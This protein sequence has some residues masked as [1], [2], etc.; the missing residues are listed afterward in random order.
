MLGS[1]LGTNVKQ[2]ISI[3]ILISLFV[4]LLSGFSATVNAA[5]LELTPATLNYVKYADKNVSYDGTVGSNYYDAKTYELSGQKYLRVSVL[6][7]AINLKLEIDGVTPTVVS[8]VYNDDDVVTAKVFDYPIESFTAPL[9]GRITYSAGG[10]QGNHPTYIVI[11]QDATANTR[12]ALKAKLLE[13]NAITNKS[14]ALTQAIAVANSVDH[15]LSREAELQAQ[16]TAL[17]T[18]IAKESVELTAATLNYVKYSD[19]NVSYDGTVGS[20]YYDA[21]TYALDGQKYL[22]V[23]VLES[24]INLKL[25]ID[26]VT[27][28]VV[29]SVYND[30]NVV[31][32][33]VFDYP[34]ESFTTPLAGRITY[35][36]GGFQGNHPTYIIINQDA[37]ADTRAALKAK[38]VE[39]NATENKSTALTQ[40]ILV[41]SGVDHLLSREAELQ[42]QLTALTTA[43]AKESVELTA[44]TLNYVKYSDKNVSY[45]GTVG[46]NYYDAKTFELNGQKYLRVSVLESAINLKLVIDGVTATEVNTIYNDDNIA[47]AKIFDYPIESFTAPIVGRITYSAGG[48]QGNHPTYI[49]INQDATAN[50]RAALK[51]KLVEAN[52]LE[53]K[54]I[55]LSQAIT[56]A[57]AIDHLLSREAELQAQLTALTTA[58]GKESVELINATLNYVKYTDKKVSY[59][60]TVGNNYYDAKTFEL[61]GQKYLRVSVLES[62]INLKLVIDGVTSTEVNT[63]YNDDNVAVAKVFDYPVE[64]FTAPIVGRITY[65][66]GG[67][68]GNHPTYI[69][70]NHDATA[71]TRAALKVKLA[72]AI[73][74]T[75]KSNALAE[76]ITAA[77]EVDHLLSREA[78]LQAQLAALTT[79]IGKD[80]VELA[81]ATLNY[82]KL[83]DKNVSFDSTV[84]NNY[85]DAKTYEF[86]GQKYLRVSVLQSSINLKLELDGVTPTV[87]SSVYNDENVITANVFD[88]P[89]NSFTEPLVGRITYTAGGRQG[90]H[91]TYI[92]INQD[93]TA[94]TRA[95]L[96]AK[97]VEANAITNKSNA[98]TEAITA[99][100][101]VDH[102]LS[103]E[104]ELQAQLSALTTAVANEPTVSPS[105]TSNPN[106]ISTPSPTVSP[107]P[108]PTVSPTPTP[109]PVTEGPKFNDVQTHWAAT[110]IERAVALG[111]TN[112]YTD[113]TFKPN[114][115]INRAEFTTLIARA[116]KLDSATETVTFSD[117][118]NIPAWAQSLIQQVVAAGIISGYEDNTFR[119]ASNISRSEMVVMIVRAL[120]LELEPAD[121]LTFD[122]SQ[123]I[124]QFAKAYVAT[125]LKHG[126]IK[127][128]TETEFGPNL[129]ASRAEALTL[130]LRAIDYAAPTEE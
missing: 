104:A 103:R 73:A 105:P 44:A 30:D 29:S 109:S 27:P 24:A 102:L 126:L 125:A 63:I 4:S 55:A 82:V 75:N 31:T 46:S 68:Q 42:A 38:L 41:A 119:A 61:N 84:G 36:A 40:A 85:Y 130:I 98:L 70:I 95:A 1:V 56:A 118:N 114:A 89:I 67:F 22:R 62:A 34:I 127:G 110:E 5:Q 54:S 101:E 121:S 25:V 37:T 117:N 66:A 88:Y 116:F 52:A 19:K 129:E 12:A 16:L 35:S 83:S 58:I 92:V 43:I 6:E 128:K 33:K 100:S 79:A 3:A 124:P 78:E 13:A 120:G 112:G 11:N 122:D 57:N 8:S 72:E 14:N 74:I 108:S 99:A 59:D 53:N 69:L 86:N 97:L 39:A 10:F 28:T 49:I 107:S 45:D 23:S 7:S 93:A 90:D 50:T 18:A 64:S 17:T 47:I 77:N 81:A 9:A 106:P 26:G 113:G 111:I 60:G 91:P 80:S 87:V 96:K 20:N 94:E 51:A 32:A 48:F 2:K 15:L 21:K 123:N 76:A 65:S 71:E 115:T